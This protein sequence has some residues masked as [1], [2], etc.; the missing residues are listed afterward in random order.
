MKLLTLLDLDQGPGKALLDATVAMGFSP[1]VARAGLSAELRAWSEPGALDMVLEELPEGLDPARRPASVLVIG[2]RTLPASMMRA[3]LMA[4]LL[5]ARVCLKPA[6][7]QAALGHALA[8]AD[9]EVTVVEFTSD[10][11]QALDGA[12]EQA[13]AVVVLGSDETVSAVR[14]RVSPEKA[15]VGYGH[16]LSVAWLAR[17]DNAA[18]LGLARDLCAWDQAG[19]LSPQVVWTTEPPAKVA[20]RLAEAV[21]GVEVA[22]PMT[23]TD[24]ALAARQTARTYGQ[25]MGEVYETETALIC[26][27]ESPTFR[28]SPGHRVLW[29]LPASIEALGEIDAH[30]STIGI[31]GSLSAPLPGSVRRCALGEMQRPSLMWAHDGLPNL[32][33][34]LRV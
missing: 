22:L 33:P 11:V 31:S 13:D 17:S 15:F 6:S 4:R 20:R 34:M 12:I 32:T 29:V 8:L 7:G 10:D 23:L 16:R 18:L 24:D 27:L 26:A 2:A 30:L 3:T 19:C 25:M 5:G 21:R 14:A 1:E 9:P 28:S